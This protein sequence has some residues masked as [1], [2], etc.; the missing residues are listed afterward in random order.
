[1]QPQDY[2]RAF[3]VG[4]AAGGGVPVRMMASSGGSTMINITTP[5]QLEDA[6]RTGTT[7]AGQVVTP[8]TALRVAAV[9]SCV[10]LI[11]G[12]V[13]NMPVSVKQR[14]DERTRRNL[15]DHPT[16]RLMNRRPNKWQKPAVFKRMMQAHVLLRGNAYAAKVRGAKGD[17][18]A[19]IP[20]HPDRVSKRQL[21][22]MSCEYTWSRLRGGPM[23]LKEAD[24]MH[25]MGLSLDGVTGC[26]PIAYMRE[27]IG[28]ARAMQAHGSSVFAN[29]ANVSGAFKL[30]KGHTLTEQQTDMLRAQL[31]EFRAGGA[32]DGKTIILED[33]LEYQQ[34]AMT[35]E[36]AQ[37]IEARK[38]SRG[39]IAMFFGVPPHM[40]GD[41]EKST[42]WGTGI[43]SQAQGFVTYTLED[44]LTMWE[45]A[46]GADCIDWDSNP[47]IYA[48]FNRNALVRGDLKARWEAY[49]KGLQWG[50]YSPNK[51]LELEDE[52]PRDGGD[53]YYD[54]P[55]AAGGAGSDGKSGDANVA[56]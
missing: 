42:S 32:R 50:V 23:V 36:D 26:S 16:W 41:T 34:M 12:A 22:D 37:W 10:R 54:P 40:I 52:N 2:Q 30:P 44:H 5:E 24:V 14:V 28:E 6:L 27:T 48:R 4:R 46:L 53:V 55:N 51:V 19:L 17:V 43:E 35:A 13:A 47:D 31:E 9:M 20:L 7:A 21:D 3:G 11:T 25:L 56:A 1:M 29:G 15:P 18:V 38:F 33:G 8:D 39:E 45:E 49:V